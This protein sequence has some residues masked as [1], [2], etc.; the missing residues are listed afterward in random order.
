MLGIDAVINRAATERVSTLIEGVHVIPKPMP[1]RQERVHEIAIII[2]VKD[3]E[4]HRARFNQRYEENP[5]RPAQQYLSRFNA[6]R[7]I[8]DYIS[9]LARR[10]DIPIINNVNLDQTVDQALEE[11]TKRVQ[12]LGIK[13][14]MVYESLPPNA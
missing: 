8:Q 9:D 3:Y 7:G 1:D 14:R 10:Y 11:I 13:P 5:E 4:T 6:I 2:E 12:K